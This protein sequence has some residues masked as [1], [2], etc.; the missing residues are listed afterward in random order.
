MARLSIKWVDFPYRKVTAAPVITDADFTVEC[1]MTT[2]GFNVTLP[3]PARVGRVLNIMRSDLS[4][5]T[6]RILPYAA[7]TIAGAPYVDLDVPWKTISL[8]STGTNWII[9]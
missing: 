9:I 7:E 6:G 4:V 5:N 3:D 2:A 8:Q 1:D